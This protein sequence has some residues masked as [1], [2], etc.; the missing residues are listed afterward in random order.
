MQGARVRS[1][2]RELRSCKPRSAAKK[3]VEF[4]RTMAVTLQK[5][6]VAG[7]CFSKELED[8]VQFLIMPHLSLVFCT[9]S[10]CHHFVLFLHNRT[11]LLKPPECPRLYRSATWSMPP[12]SHSWARFAYKAYTKCRAL[13]TNIDIFFSPFSTHPHEIRAETR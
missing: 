12:E 5:G 11:D 4:V 9:V 2:V 10:P 1:L 7:L 3:K 6:V 8:M 13:F